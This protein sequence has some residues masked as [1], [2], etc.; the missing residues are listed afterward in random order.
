[1]PD[2]ECLP[3]NENKTFAQM[4]TDFQN[5]TDDVLSEYV[6]EGYL[7]TIARVLMYMSNER[8]DELLREFDQD[9]RQKIMYFQRC[10]DNFSD[11]YNSKDPYIMEAESAFASMNFYPLDELVAIERQRRKEYKEEN[12]EVFDNF[13]EQNPIYGEYLSKL[14]FEF[15]TIL[16]LDDRAIQKILREVDTHELAIAL[17]NCHDQ[18]RNK[19]YSNISENAALRIKEMIENYEGDIRAE[20]IEQ[21]RQKIC[22]VILRLENSGEIVIASSK[23]NQKE[24]EQ[25]L[26]ELCEN[27]FRDKDEDN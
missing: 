9:K 24:V 6:R 25:K 21:A 20:R 15:G 13:K 1:M 5:L 12:R 26:N 8:A 4:L 7:R 10:P 16:Y 27:M 11:A 17:V 19:I 14:H 22:S 23:D 2:K 3:T 18:I